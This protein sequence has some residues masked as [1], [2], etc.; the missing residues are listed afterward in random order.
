MIVHAYSLSFSTETSPS[1]HPPTA[2]HCHQGDVEI[3]M[4][5][6]VD[7]NDDEEEIKID[8]CNKGE[9]KRAKLVL[10]PYHT[11]SK[12]P[13][14]IVTG[15]TGTLQVIVSGNPSSSQHLK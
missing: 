15:S 9:H 5:A 3:D 6:K 7:D 1:R 12:L 2:H 8:G 13:R 4:A 14:E 11:Q 10:A